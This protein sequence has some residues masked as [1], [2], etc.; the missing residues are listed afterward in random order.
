MEKRITKGER[1]RQAVIYSSIYYFNKFGYKQVGIEELMQ[2]LRLTTGVF[3]A[4][5]QGKDELLTT[6][7]EIQIQ[8]VRQFLFFSSEPLTS[9]AWIRQFV[10]FYLS[11]N[12]RDFVGMICPLPR[13]AAELHLEGH[14]AYA[15]IQ[16]Y[17]MQLEG[18]LQK[19]LVDCGLDQKWSATGLISMCL[20]ALQMARTEPD[21]ARSSQILHETQNSLKLILNLNH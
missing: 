5:F 4:N 14:S 1:T 11:Q 17:R 9:E 12:H 7:L 18:L 8:N 10:E 13:L 15:K 6:S 21:P 2:S 16:K 20:G 3:Y 19:R